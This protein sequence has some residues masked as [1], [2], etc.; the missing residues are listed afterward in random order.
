[1]VQYGIIRKDKKQGWTLCW[2]SN[3]S[4]MSSDKEAVERTMASVA[5]AFPKEKYKLLTSE[6]ETWQQYGLLSLIHI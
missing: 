6:E 5:A 3:S 1:M 2:T 4:R